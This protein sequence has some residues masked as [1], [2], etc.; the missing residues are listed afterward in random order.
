MCFTEDD[1]YGEKKGTHLSTYARIEKFAGNDRLVTYSF[2]E[3]KLYK[4][5]LI[6]A[7]LDDKKNFKQFCF[8]KYGKPSKIDNVID[9]KFIWSGKKG[10]V[11]YWE[12]NFNGFL[13]LKSSYLEDQVWKNAEDFSSSYLPKKFDNEPEGFRNIK[14]GTEKSKI[15]NVSFIDKDKEGL[16]CYLKIDDE[17]KIGNVDV[18]EI[19]YLFWNNVFYGVNILVSGEDNYLKMK[20]SCF[21]KFGNEV[22]E[23]SSPGAIRWQGN[24]TTTSLYK[25]DNG[26]LMFIYSTK[27]QNEKYQERRRE[28]EPKGF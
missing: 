11:E 22:N 20:R 21:I 26:G 23:D 14:W 19:K 27:K 15:D 1:F 13:S 24:A 18:K 28:Q 6:A 10:T 2:W 9:E 5:D 16:D 7:G 17:F 25:S 8:S 4:I 3:N 12:T